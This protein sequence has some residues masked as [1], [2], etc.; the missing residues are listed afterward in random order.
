[1]STIYKTISGDTFAE[2]A[3]KTV[4]S[5]LEELAIRQ[6]NPGV[7][8]PLTPGLEILIPNVQKTQKKAP[9]VQDR[10]QASISVNGQAVTFFTDYAI[11]KTLDSID[12]ASFS[13]PF[14]SLGFKPLTFPDCDIFLGKEPIFSGTIVD[15]SVNFNN[16]GVTSDYT[17]YSKSGVLNECM[18]PINA[19]PLEFRNLDLK[20]ISERLT[21]PYGIGVDFLSDPGGPFVQVALEPT[22]NILKFLMDLAKQRNLLVRSDPQ[23]RLVFESH[24]ASGAPV[25]ILKEGESAILNIE[26][27]FDPQNY[28]S[29]ITGITSGNVYK[30]ST[31]F[32]AKN[33]RLNNVLR[34]FNFN[35]EDGGAK[36][37]TESKLR[38]MI[39]NCV[40]Y[41]F[42]VPSLRDPSGALWRPNTT[43]KLLY[44]SVFIEKE[45]EFLIETVSLKSDRT[46]ALEVVPTIDSVGL[47]WDV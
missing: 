8:E 34:N 16:Q 47:P 46:A 40:K 13:A 37:A 35:I 11:K 19:F 18:A 12:T 28:F 2:I 45:F 23:G 30:P 3:R 14:K 31:N 22:E 41:S 39:L 25:A 26:V 5:E 29:H 6:A 36:T 42:N 38:R 17:C 7:I 4:G 15:V 21:A 20:Q 33:S 32:T 9:Q 43:V 27:D 24:V 10:N 1:M 44:P